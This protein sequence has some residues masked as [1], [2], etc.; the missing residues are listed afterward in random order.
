MGS[1]KLNESQAADASQDAMFDE[2][3]RFRL[4]S[5][6]SGTAWLVVIANEREWMDYRISRVA[7]GRYISIRAN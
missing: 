5:L 2:W 6:Q 4:T 7:G 1:S 3:C